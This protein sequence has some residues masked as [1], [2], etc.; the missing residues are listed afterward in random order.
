MTEMPKILILTPIKDAV[1]YLETY[2][3]L[4]EQLT[5][6]PSLISIGLIEGDSRDESFA[7]FQERLKTLDGKFRRTG[8]WQKDFGFKIPPGV[9]RWADPLQIPRRTVLAK[10]RNH[11]L[12]HAL[13]DED[14]VLWIDVD[15]D[16]YP[17]D[18]IEQLLVYD[19]DILNPHC[20]R[21]FGKSTFD[22]NAWRDKGK[23][24]MQDL[25]DEGELVR[26]DAVGAAMLLIRADRHRDGLIFPSFPYGVANPRV[27]DAAL[28]ELESEGLG[29]MAADMGIQSWGVTSIEVRHF[30]PGRTESPAT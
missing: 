6:P 25:R 12:F 10:A 4:L 16:A 2:F 20:V 15:V 17:T 22:H 11:L 19:Q 30:M 26:L 27:R 23:L 13:D 18:I 7:A 5:Y 3:Q 28:G 21:E 29:L 8:I 9:A 24:H 14:W 1:P